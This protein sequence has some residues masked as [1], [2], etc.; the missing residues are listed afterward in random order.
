MVDNFLVWIQGANINKRQNTEIQRHGH[1]RL[2]NIT[3]K[4]TEQFVAKIYM[5]N[6]HCAARSGALGSSPIN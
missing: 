5:Q 1:T 3:R 4:L 6:T 2:I